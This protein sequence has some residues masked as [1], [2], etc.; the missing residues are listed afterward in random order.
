MRNYTFLILFLL[1]ILS[2]KE[3]E[4]Q[5]PS[6][7]DNGKG[8]GGFGKV[9]F[10]SNIDAKYIPITV[11][12]DTA[13][14][15]NLAETFVV[16]PNC[17]DT[18]TLIAEK[19]SN[20]YSYTATNSKGMKWSGTVTLSE[21][22]C[23]KVLLNAENT[24]KGRCCFWSDA[25]FHIVGVKPITIFLESQNKGELQS[26]HSGTPNCGD[27][28]TVT[29]D[30]LQAGIYNFSA[31]TQSGKTCSGVIEIVSDSCASI[32]ISYHNGVLSYSKVKSK[33]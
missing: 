7:G 6:A 20:T 18:K 3:K 9:S 17:G 22:G 31:T 23:E 8:I 14:L 19:V 24:I 5:Y 27:I 30:N 25:D 10:W 16:E 26:A 12:F 13:I 1:Q 11:K 32:K 29:V 21:Y 15:G 33:Q 2:C 28:N 4:I